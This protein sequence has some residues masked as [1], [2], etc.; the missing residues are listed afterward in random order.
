MSVTI[1]IIIITVFV[2]WRAWQDRQF[3]EH[4]LFVPAA[5]KERGEYYRFISSGFI[6]SGTWHLFF[7]MYAFWIFGQVAE[8]TFAAMFGPTFG[9]PAMLVFYLVSIIAANLADY[10]RHQ[11]NYAYR[12][13]GA[14]GGVAAMLWPFVLIAPW[15]WF[16]FP[17]MPAVILGPAYIAY[18]YYMDK[19]GRDNIGHSAHLWGAVFG[20]IAYVLLA[21]ALEP[22]LIALFLERVAQPQWPAY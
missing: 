4:L 14:S 8:S 12:A 7:N 3:Q 13:L 22:G 9:Q 1:I 6:H 10:Y 21:L 11:D 15:N 16:L 5:I 2:T 20:L 18:S 19:R 17:P